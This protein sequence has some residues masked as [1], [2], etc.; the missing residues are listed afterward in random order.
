M[1]TLDTFILLYLQ[2]RRDFVQCAREG[3]VPWLLDK[4]I[5]YAVDPNG[6]ET[7]SVRLPDVLTNAHV[8]DL[9]PDGKWIGYSLG[10]G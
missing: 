10:G 2:R 9:S 3:G 6:S 8:A 1:D 4:V 7:Y 5:L